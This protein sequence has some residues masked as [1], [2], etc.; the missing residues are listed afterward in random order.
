MEDRYN[1]GMVSAKNNNGESGSYAKILGEKYFNNFLERLSA[2][3]MKGYYTQITQDT[4]KA[5]EAEIDQSINPKQITGSVLN[6]YERI[7]LIL[8]GKQALEWLLKK[9]GYENCVVAYVND[10]QTFEAMSC[11][12]NFKIIIPL[13]DVVRKKWSNGELFSKALILCAADLLATA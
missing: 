5:V 13:A 8:A 3:S 10:S 1:N 7:E 11:T 9:I 4:V 6:A 2:D 12:D